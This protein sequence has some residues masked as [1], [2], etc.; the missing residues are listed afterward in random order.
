MIDKYIVLHV[1]IEYTVRSALI[2]GFLSGVLVTCLV[3]LAKPQ[4]L[5]WVEACC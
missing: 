2:G 1:S 4:Q 3:K 5:H